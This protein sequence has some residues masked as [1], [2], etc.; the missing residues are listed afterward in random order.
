MNKEYCEKIRISAMAISDGEQ[1]LLPENEIAVHL[2][3]C[4]EC[5]IAI[6]QFQSVEKLLEGKQRKSSD[7]NIVRE[8]ETALNTA[9]MSPGYFEYSGRFIIFVAVL[10][11]LKVI[12]LSPVE[13]GWIITRSLTILIVIVF[14]VLIKRNP[15][16]INE[17]L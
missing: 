7:V 5:R 14:F 9:M 10:L 6:E 13:T 12:G 15:F 16:A 8:V 17:N 1:A 4:N 3:S 2:E 11:I